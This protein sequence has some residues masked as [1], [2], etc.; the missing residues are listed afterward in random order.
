MEI[1]DVF[2]PEYLIAGFIMAV[3][4]A[5]LGYLL[6][7]IFYYLIIISGAYI[8]SNTSLYNVLTTTISSSSSLPLLFSLIMFVL[9]FAGG[10][11]MEF[12]HDNSA[13]AQGQ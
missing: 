13:K 2:K 7:T 6:G 11:Y 10:Y 12:K 9:G 1:R 8:S 5:L 4:L 3:L